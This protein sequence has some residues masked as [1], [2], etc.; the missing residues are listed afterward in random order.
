LLDRALVAL[1]GAARGTLQGPVQ[2][3]EQAPHMSRVMADLG[4]PLD[5][6]RHPGQRPQIR[7]EAR[8][9]GPGPQ[10]PL[11]L[12]QLRRPEL[13]LA[14]RS[15]R[16]LQG[17]ATVLLPGVK[18]VM[19]GD[20]RDSQ[21]ACHGALRLVLREQARRSE[22]TRFQRGK[23]PARSSWSGHASPCDRT[24]EIR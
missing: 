23:I 1:A 3:A 20:P 11:D 12:R 9:L 7:L 14:A 6:L 8:D 2:A 19:G 21:R 5:D 17:P 24:H 4:K 13:R 18:P 16:G 15:A 22:P 10:R